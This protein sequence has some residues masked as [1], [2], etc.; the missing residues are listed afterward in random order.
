MTRPLVPLSPTHARIL[1]LSMHMY[2]WLLRIGPRAFSEEYGESMLQVFRQC[3]IDA[4]QRRGIPAVLLLWLP[5]F[6]DLLT[7]VITEHITQ[8]YALSTRNRFALAG[9]IAS[10][11]RNRTMLRTQRRSTL[12]IFVS[13]ILFGLAW[14]NFFRLNDPLSLWLPLVRQHPEIDV[15]Y[16]VIK[17][18]GQIALLVLLVGGAPLLFT[19]V[20]DTWRTRRRNILLWFG[21][22]A[23]LL[24]LFVAII[25][26]ILFV[27]TWW[28]HIDP[29]G[30]IFFIVFLLAL[31]VGAISIWRAIIRSEIS[32]HLLRFALLSATVVI[33]A[34]A[35]A[36]FA[37]LVEGALFLSYVPATLNGNDIINWVIA[38]V[39]M[40]VAI[41]LST[42]ALWQGLHTRPSAL[43]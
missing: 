8:L 30:G 28:K 23:L 26:I 41:G 12:I 18:A 43:A 21:M 42:F 37:S 24:I 39:M 17:I 9:G 11:E 15:T 25:A 3:C 2:R 22:T 19:V 10:S 34:M 1:A 5:M 35:V 31:V 14:L 32:A 4:L 38:D 20:R 13:F 16:R 40:V 29:N 27:P 6:G 33:V 36:L 7:G